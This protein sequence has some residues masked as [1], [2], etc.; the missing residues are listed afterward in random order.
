MRLKIGW[1]VPVIAA[2]VVFVHA[3]SSA[4][5]PGAVKWRTYQNDRYGVTIDYPDFFRPKPPPDADDGRA[6]ESTD[7]AEFAVFASY[8]TLDFDVAAFRDF[9]I[10]NRNAGEV[11]TYQSQGRNWFVISGTKGS[12]RVF[13]ERHLLSHKGEMTN[14]F[15]MSYPSRLKQKYDPIVARMSKSL[16]AGTGY[17]SPD[18]P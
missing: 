5:N 6:F 14:G 18:K 1:A 15:V 12:D 2:A 9:T 17:Q 4:E 7:G 8:N 10:K 3:A 13:Y 11:V 16:R